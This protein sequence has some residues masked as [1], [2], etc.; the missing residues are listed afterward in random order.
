MLKFITFRYIHI[1]SLNSSSLSL[2]ALLKFFRFLLVSISYFLK[3]AKDDLEL[4][5]IPFLFFYFCFKEINVFQT[6]TKQM[7]F[8]VAVIVVEKMRRAR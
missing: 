3:I 1:S 6:R 8:P 4:S 7:L 2:N 5:K